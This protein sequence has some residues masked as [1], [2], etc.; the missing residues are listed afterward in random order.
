MLESPTPLTK[1]TLAMK[2][3]NLSSI[4]TCP[5]FEGLNNGI[6]IE[7]PGNSNLSIEKRL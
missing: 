5:L 2:L 3:N 4:E 6:L 7:K 1:G